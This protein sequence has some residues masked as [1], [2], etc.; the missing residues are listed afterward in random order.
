MQ[1]ALRLWYKFQI[2]KPNTKLQSNVILA[3]RYHSWHT[4]MFL[5]SE[6]RCLR[7]ETFVYAELDNVRIMI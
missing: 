3:P 1:Q 6:G 4:K 2:L 5:I 7:V